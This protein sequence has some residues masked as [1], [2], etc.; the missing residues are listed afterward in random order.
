M[1]ITIVAGARPNFIKI[2]PII[3]AVKTAHARGID[4]SYR[5][6]HT[7]QHYDKKMSGDFFD[8]LD[9][10]NPDVNLE[11]GSGSQAE[12]TASIMI[13]FEKELIANKPSVVLVVGDV[14]S[15]M[16]CSITA[17]KLNN[18]KVAH[19]EAGLRTESVGPVHGRPSTHARSAGREVDADKRAGMRRRLHPTV[20]LDQQRLPVVR[21]DHLLGAGETVQVERGK[22]SAR[23]Q[24]APV[25][26]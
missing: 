8:Q 19:V 20:N 2:A 11:C 22:E 18:I 3:R 23:R 10:P 24:V 14:T 9:I 4:I 21:L 7:G 13:K 12:Q 5:L 25:A 17:K 16:A 6:V 1:Q 15:T 26:K